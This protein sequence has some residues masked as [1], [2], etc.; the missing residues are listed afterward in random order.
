MHPLGI[1]KVTVSHQTLWIETE[2]FLL[3]KNHDS[4]LDKCNH[5]IERSNFFYLFGML[6]ESTHKQTPSPRERN[7]KPCEVEV[8]NYFTLTKKKCT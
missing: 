2:L 5:G 7:K 3:K 4:D 8:Y 6:S 1:L